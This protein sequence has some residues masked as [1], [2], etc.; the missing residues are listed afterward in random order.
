MFKLKKDF[1]KWVLKYRKKYIPKEYNQLLWL[2]DLTKDTIDVYLS[3]TNRGD[4]KSFNTI[5]ACLKMGYDL[6]LKPIFIVR[7]WELQTLFRNLI[8]NV[9]ETLE[10]WEVENLWY[11]NQQDYII[12]GYEDKEIGLIADINNASDLKFSSFKL[13]EFPL[14]VYDEFLALDDDY[15]PNELQKI[16]TIYQSIDRVKPK[17][18]PFGI[19]PKMILL[20]NPINFNSPILEWLDFY[21]LIEKH[22]MNTI[23]QY[24]NKLI[25][26]RQNEQVN[27]NKNTSIFDVE[28][29]SN[30][31]GMFEI[32]HHNL[33]SK[34]LFDKI[35]SEV[36]PSIIKLESDKYINFYVWKG[37][38]VIDITSKGDYQYCLNLE[39]RKDDVIYLYP[40]KYFNDTFHN[41]Y[42]KDVIKFTN[43]FSKNYI[44]NNPNYMDLNLFKLINYNTTTTQQKVE[45]S[46]ERIL[47]QKL[48]KMYENL[49]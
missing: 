4:G 1:K 18:R 21:S 12:I 24:G 23:K 43:T 2:D 13:K 25:E 6:D 35:K 3:I 38:Y 29:D 36:C 7:H 16:K 28:N 32:N 39:D 48:G 49:S 27:K 15:M 34:E 22:K 10:F 11:V 9:V 44:Y 45:I 37:N 19:K 17:D 8:D 14:M 30:F 42:R 20:A 46:K 26:L 47:L 40:N 33:I 41:K 31:T 5:G